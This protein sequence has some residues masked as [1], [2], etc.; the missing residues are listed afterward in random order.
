MTMD[1]IVTTGATVEAALDVALDELS[2]T[3]EDI[4]FEVVEKPKSSIFGFRRKQAQVRARVRPMEPPAKREWRKSSKTDKGKKARKKS[5]NNK[6]R[7]SQATDKK[8][9]RSSESSQNKKTAKP[10]RKQNKAAP[11]PTP[12]KNEEVPAASNTRKR[13]IGTSPQKSNIR[14]INAKNESPQSEPPKVRRTRKIDH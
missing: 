2:V 9:P 3:Q 6:T 7:T 12:R 5:Q 8:A 10:Q 4:E 11:T 14:S 1:W 13:T